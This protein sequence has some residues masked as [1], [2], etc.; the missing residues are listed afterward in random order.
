MNGPWPR[1]LRAH[2]VEG[3]G[4]MK[5]NPGPKERI[6]SFRDPLGQWDSE[7]TSA[8]RALEYFFFQCPDRQSER[9]PFRVFPPPLELGRPNSTFMLYFQARENWIPSLSR[10]YCLGANVQRSRCFA[11][12]LDLIFDPRCKRTLARAKRTLEC[13]VPGCVRLG[14]FPCTGQR[15]PQSRSE[16]NSVPK[17]VEEMFCRLSFFGVELRSREN[18]N[19]RSR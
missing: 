18:R 4:G 5:R 14:M 9:S 10:L 7:E 19:D 3:A 13:E 8:P 17:I 6:Y 16:G 12:W 11:K 1:G 2:A 15:S